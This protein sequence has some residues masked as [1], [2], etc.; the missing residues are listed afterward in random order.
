MKVQAAIIG[1]LAGACVVTIVHEIMKR[2]IP[3]APRMDKLGMEA[4]EKGMDKADQPI[5]ER[6]NLFMLSLIGELFSNTLYYSLTGIG[7]RKDSSKKGNLLGVVAG[8]GAIWLP[9][10]MG[11]NDKHSNRTF[12]TKVLALGLYLLGGIVAS[13]VT[14]LVDKQSIVA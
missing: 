2:N 8:L 1:G 3:D 13:Q 7:K 4:I 6:K 12:K 9:K 11:L 5:P 10:P 14:K